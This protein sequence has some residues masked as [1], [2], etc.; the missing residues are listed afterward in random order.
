MKKIILYVFLFLIYLTGCSLFSSNENENDKMVQ[1]SGEAGTEEFSDGMG[2]VDSNQEMGFSEQGDVST[3]ESFS[4]DS[5]D[6]YADDEYADDEYGNSSG[7]LVNGDDIG[8]PG[9]PMTDNQEKDLFAQQE[10]T[11]YSD[12][13]SSDQMSSMGEPRKLIPVKKMKSSVYQIS[14]AN[15]NRLYVV[16][17][18]DDMQSIATKI[19]GGDRSEDIYSYNS[20]FRGKTL[21]VGDKIYYQSPHNP[22][23]SMMKTYYEDNNLQPQYYVTQEGDNLRKI[24]KRFL[25]HGRSW[26]EIYATNESVESKGRLPAGLNIRYWPDSGMSV[27]ET[28][29]PQDLSTAP[30]EPAPEPVENQDQNMAMDQGQEIQPEENPN[31][32][33]MSNTDPM[34]EPIA[35]TGD[36]NNF[37]DSQNDGNLPPPPA[38]PA[39]INNQPSIE[40][41]MP[42]PPAK[43]PVASK[44]DSK[45]FTEDQKLMAALFCLMLLV[46]IILLILIRRNRSRKVNFG[47]TQ[48]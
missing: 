35:Q 31:T 45:K 9:S 20:H 8:L 36:I 10:S 40:P 16:R 19:Y 14:G 22:T 13:S 46:A 42:P 44:K 7:E 29:N 23:D 32:G 38:V 11:S 39:E 5:V 4:G 15:I 3:E 48:S 37:N 24:S 34:E 6:E 18:G 28:T 30:P 26:M 17:P 27:A 1:P 25:G 12:F 21:N 43:K 33:D 47:H 41:A 2:E